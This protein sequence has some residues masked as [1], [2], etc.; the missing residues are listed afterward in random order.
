M[1][2]ITELTLFL[3]ILRYESTYIIGTHLYNDF[4]IYMPQLNKFNFNIQT[5]LMNNDIDIVLPSNNDILKSFIDI[6]YR[7]VDF[8]ADDKFISN[9]A[10]CHV[11]S[12]PYHFDNFIYMTS[13]F[14]GGMFNKVRLLVMLDIRP[15]ENELFK[16]ISQDFPSL[17]RLSIYNLKAQQNKH[18][19]HIFITFP[20]LCR[21]DL[22]HAHIDY[23]V[24]F[25]FDINASLPR[26][27]YLFIQYETLATITEGFTNDAARHT[28][29]SN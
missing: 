7:Q 29:F 15:F 13:R 21:L 12:I 6:G 22:A 2:N 8:Y 16:I 20:H 17:Q 24:Q 26:L 3:S 4:L 19:S 25:L 27:T 23:G 28:L 14:Q 9:R 11:Y 10:N 5:L 18:N 1:S